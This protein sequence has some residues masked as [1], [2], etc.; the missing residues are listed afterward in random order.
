LV[1]DRATNKQLNSLPLFWAFPSFVDLPSRIKNRLKRS[2]KLIASNIYP[3]LFLLQHKEKVERTLETN[4][5][6]PS[7]WNALNG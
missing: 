4:V 2:D 7:G 6:L 5:V 1:V 3:I